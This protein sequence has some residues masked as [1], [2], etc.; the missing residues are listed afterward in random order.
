MKLYAAIDLMRGGMVRLRKG[1]AS[2]VKLYPGD[3]V[4]VAQRW[5]RAGVGGLHVVDLDGAFG[6]GNNLGV[7]RR[8][9][10][11]SDTPVQVGGGIRDA[12]VARELIEAGAD[13]L[14]IGTVALTDETTFGQISEV[15]TTPK[16][17]VALDYRGEDVLMKGWRERSGIRL[18]DALDRLMTSGLRTFLLTSAERDGMMHG[19]D[20]DTIRRLCRRYGEARFFASGGVRSSKDVVALRD[21]GAYAV[22]VGKALLEGTLPISEAITIGAG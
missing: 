12:E 18:S 14:V 9:I 15:T 19:P 21:A 4:D 7:I 3:P 5:S 16:I 13:A 2:D 11:S 6:Q 17:V 10:R 20:V 22:V 8:I 1:R